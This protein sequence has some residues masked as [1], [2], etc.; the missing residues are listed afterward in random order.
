[1]EATEERLTA[2]EMTA[3]MDQL[4]A[5]S[6]A[7]WR[8][9]LVFI[10]EYDRTEAYRADAMVSMADWLVAR[11]GLARST[12]NSWVRAAHALEELPAVADAPDARAARRRHR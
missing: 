8:E 4:H 6:M 7:T 3:A 9:L 10:A 2:E 12:A 11:Y 1:M 5:V